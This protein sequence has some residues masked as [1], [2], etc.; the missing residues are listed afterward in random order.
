MEAYFLRDR[1]PQGGYYE[2]YRSKPTEETIRKTVVEIR[3]G[4]FPAETWLQI[5]FAEIQPDPL[6]HWDE[7]ILPC[8]EKAEAF[9]TREGGFVNV[10]E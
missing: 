6:N 10:S 9:W 8:W 3:K 1:D 7:L 4:D 5:N 2:I